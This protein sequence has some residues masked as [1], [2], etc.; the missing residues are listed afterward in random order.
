MAYH[1]SAKKRIRQTEYRTE[2]NGA[3]L[4]QIRTAVKAVESA[5]AAGKK[6]EAQNAFKAAKPL[7]MSGVSKGIF[8]LTTASR[9][10]SRLSAKVKSVSAAT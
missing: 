6:A 9:K 2:V 4:S 10:V 1:K 3:R 8:K 7:I 5:V